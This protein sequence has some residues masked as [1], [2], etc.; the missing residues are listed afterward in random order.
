MS[1]DSS[2][3]GFG[4]LLKIDTGEGP[5]TRRGSSE[6][7]PPLSALNLKL[8]DGP[9]VRFCS[10]KR[11]ANAAAPAFTGSLVPSGETNQETLSEELRQPRSPG[12]IV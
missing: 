2:A 4:S 6:E 10:K 9:A 8:Y 5:Q 1:R 7:F 3:C 11:H 12:R